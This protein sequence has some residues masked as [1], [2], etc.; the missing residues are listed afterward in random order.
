M[1]LTILILFGIFSLVP[2]CAGEEP[3]SIPPENQV[4]LK[5]QWTPT[6]EQ[7]ERA[8]A[9]AT[10]LVR[11]IAAQPTG[12][13]FAEKYKIEGAAK[14]SKEMRKYFVQFIGQIRNGKK[15]VFCNFFRTDLWK[16]SFPDWKESEV[17]VDDG[18][19]SYWQVDYD[20]ETGKCGELRI[21]GPG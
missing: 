10:A 18:G 7:T 21:N 14:I 4:I 2:V 15:V 19:Y 9:A 3:D 16:Y 20:P 12:K 13:T 17:M 6:K 1:R 11:Q 5:G 8:L